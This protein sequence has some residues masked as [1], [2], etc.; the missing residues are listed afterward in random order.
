MPTPPETTPRLLM[1]PAKVETSESRIAK[2]SAEIVPLLV[3]PPPNVVVFCT[4]MP[5]A[6]PVPLVIRAV[7]VPLLETCMPPTMTPPLL[8]S[9]PAL[10]A[11]IVPL[12]TSAP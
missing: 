9:M 10:V 8:T 12:S 2:R 6:D 4:T 7:I 11:R 3:M 1:P 5:L